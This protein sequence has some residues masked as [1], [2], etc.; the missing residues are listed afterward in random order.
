MI[1]VKAH[2]CYLGKTGFAAHARG[3]FRE[4]SKYVDLRVRNYTWDDSPDYLN[5]TDTAVLQE[6]TL[7]NS[8]GTKS[9]YPFS[10]SFP[11]LQFPTDSFAPDVD[12][13]LMDINH[14][15]F[16]DNY[17]A[18]VKIAYTVWESTELPADFFQCLLDRF[19]YLWVPTEWHKKMAIRQGY[20]WHRVFIVNEGVDHDF[21]HDQPVKELDEY[22]DGRFKFLFFGRWDYRKAVPEIV[23]AFLEAFG[24]DEP[25][26]LVLSA[27]NPYSVD[28][29]NSTEE[30]LE[31]YGLVSPS[32]KVKH[33]V[34]REDYVS[35]MKTGNVFLS[36]ARS[37]GWN[38]PLI[39]AMAAGTPAIYSDWG[40]Q[41]EFA[42]GRGLPVKIEKEL[43]ANIGAKLGFAGAT[44]GLY[45]EPDYGHL[46]QVMRNAYEE[47]ES[48]KEKAKKQANEIRSRFSWEVAGV[49]GLHAIEEAVDR[50]V[51]PHKRQEAAI[52]MSH[53]DNQERQE[54]LQ[55]CIL[56]LKKQGLSVIVSSHIPVPDHIWSISDYV[57][58]DRENPLVYYDESHK[59]TNSGVI[60]YRYSPEWEIRRS[61]HFNHSYAAIKLMKNG[62]A[63]AEAN[64]FE[65]AHFVNYDYV[66]YNKK[67]IDT[68]SKEL[69]DYHVVGYRG[70]GMDFI[71]GF[72][73][74]KTSY[75]NRAFSAMVDKASYYSVD[76]SFPVCENVVYSVF[77]NAGLSIQFLQD[78]IMKHGNI[79]NE[80]VLEVNEPIETKMYVGR[81]QNQTPCFTCI[82]KYP[83]N[84]QII[85]KDKIYEIEAGPEP[86]FIEIPE[87]YLEDG[88]RIKNMKT[89]EVTI[90]NTQSNFASFNILNPA[91]KRR[92]DEKEYAGEESDNYYRIHFIDGPFVEIVGNKK[93]N[94][95][96]SFIDQETDTAIYDTIIGNNS[97]ARCNRKYFTNWKIE[98][99]NLRT[100]NTQTHNYNAEGRNVYVTIDSSSLGDSIAWFAHLEEFQ[101]K[102][103]CI[104]YVSTFN[105]GLFE[106]EYPD[107]LFV[108]PGT[109]VL[110]LYAK[111]SIGWFYDEFNQP[112]LN[113]NPRDFR[114]I[115]MQA[116]TTDI[117][118]LPESCVAPRIA[119]P[120]GG[121]PIDGDYVCIAIH[122]T[123]QAKYWNNPTGW[124]E[125][126]DHFISK[127]IKV[128]LLSREPDGYMG[129]PSPV[130]V[131]PPLGERTLENAML[132]LKHA[133]M[134]IGLGSGLSWLA[135]ASGTPTVIIS[136]FS[137]PVSEPQDPS[138]I[139][140]FN[141]DVCNGCFNRHRLDAGDWNW[142]PD[143]KGTERQFECSKSITGK[144]VIDAINGITPKKSK[145]KKKPVNTLEIK[146]YIPIEREWP[147]L[148]EQP[149]P[150]AW[151]NIPT[152]LKDVVKRFNVPTSRCLEFGVEYGYSTSALSHYFDEVIGVDTFLGDSHSGHKNNHLEE[153]SKYLEPYKNI[154]LV[155][156]SYQDFIKDNDDIYG[157]IH[158][159]IIHDFLH[160]FEC[161]EWSVQHA[162]VTVFHDTLSFPEV[163][164]A[165]K[166]L[167]KKYNL[168]FHNYEE[169][170]GLGIL[171]NNRIN[172]T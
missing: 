148:A 93:S 170:H 4:L 104:L 23:K 116:T 137:T 2:T 15:Y 126:V 38:I 26:D 59:F 99:T 155:K 95:L 162:K 75:F 13:V 1:R 156:A 124:Q 128:V 103:K 20:P 76:C 105:N 152:I 29:M 145:V 27:D 53:A 35:Y 65:K 171:V 159:D 122:S 7:N 6:I 66:L 3:F 18:P 123:A 85:A 64:G 158:V 146:K 144:Q 60:G 16:F 83:T 118:G 165:C 37:E 92:L 42:A 5:E 82:S 163:M 142:C 45:A 68:H 30:R 134:F 88:F 57:I 10:H 22:A 74:A 136:G 70:D 63:L 109:P 51:A 129:N 34:S 61:F 46:S 113:E 164:R 96:V 90:Y 125:V 71:T 73:S 84:L 17:T 72:F 120:E 89:G 56:E 101:K 102:H 58:I 157:L 40:A 19:D 111:Y 167:A 21:C 108:N 81:D 121:P 32:I 14:H 31:H 78:D 127:G 98:V 132:Y 67:T 166:E 141:S 36:C 9:D 69:D 25:V 44:P 86:V 131:I 87:N 133:K 147:P 168:E 169:S 110:D 39:E 154:K 79:I 106:K 114:D 139:R 119:V 8:D 62:S 28:G 80:V 48:Y 115:P 143:Q 153:T 43:P 138:I 161:G 49:Q 24:K 150:S 91:R 50:K 97:W 77:R 172:N 55:K 11:H 41:L 160:T 130:G 100:G 149:H 33:F 112:K 117:L 54:L 47:Y 151:Q 94:Y 135:W 107:I 52:I 12:I 140:V